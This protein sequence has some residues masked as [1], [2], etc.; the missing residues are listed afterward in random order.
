MNTSTV[1][2]AFK[3]IVIPCV[4]RNLF[5]GILP[6]TSIQHAKLCLAQRVLNPLASGILFAMLSISPLHA[7][8]RTTIPTPPSHTTLYLHG[9]IYTN[10]PAHP[11]ASALAVRDGKI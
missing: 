5:S 6:P 1:Y 3:K 7:Q 10:D 9:R 4:G 2:T 8:T 11:W